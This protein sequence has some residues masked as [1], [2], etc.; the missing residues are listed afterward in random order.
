MM[1][2][3][4]LWKTI[5]GPWFRES[6]PVKV[7][8]EPGL[9]E[10]RGARGYWDGT[11][12]VIDA[13]SDDMGRRVALLHELGH[14]VEDILIQAGL[15]PRRIT[16]DYLPEGSLTLFYLLAEAAVLRGVT[17][18]KIEEWVAATHPASGER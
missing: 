3:R 8:L 16:H 11:E 14:V 6:G 1:M 9:F 13:D 2:G 12:I 5:D 18:S 4:R 17:P 7:W 10:R 15:L